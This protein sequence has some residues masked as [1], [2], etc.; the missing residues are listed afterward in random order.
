M[1]SDEKTQQISVEEIR[2]NLDKAL[3]DVDKRRTAGIAQLHSVRELKTRVLEREQK[4]YQNM[5]AEGGPRAVEIE[6]RLKLNKQFAFGLKLET[7][8]ARREPPSADDKTWVLDGYVRDH[9]L[10]GVGGVTIALFDG[11]EQQLKALGRTTSDDDGYFKLIAVKG[12]PESTKGKEVR[13]KVEADWC[14][15]ARPKEGLPDAYVH[16][17]QAKRRLYIHPQPVVPQRGRTDYVEIY[18]PGADSKAKAGPAR[19]A[20]KKKSPPP[21]TPTGK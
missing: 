7:E 20:P 9:K 11:H 17:F 14:T 21:A 19:P 18:L 10:R 5:G 8:R 3:T 1:K 16:V 6:R 15:P 2:G 13:G 4:R 12:L